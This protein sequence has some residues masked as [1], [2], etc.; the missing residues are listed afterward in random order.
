MTEKPDN[1]AHPKRDLQI[2]TSGAVCEPLRFRRKDGKISWHWVVT[3]FT[4]DSH[5]Q[6]EMVFPKEQAETSGELLALFA[7]ENA[8]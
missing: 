7:E 1:L 3:E 8:E 6:G 2:H 5:R 4:D